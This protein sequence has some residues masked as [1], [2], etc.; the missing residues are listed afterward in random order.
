[1]DGWMSHFVDSNR[2]NIVYRV[3][4]MCM[5]IMVFVCLMPRIRHAKTKR[6]QTR[7]A[8]HEWLRSPDMME[9]QAQPPGCRF[10]LSSPP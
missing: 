3:P 10:G 1:M 4:Y 2:T 9:R 5:L 8:T 7:H 6:S